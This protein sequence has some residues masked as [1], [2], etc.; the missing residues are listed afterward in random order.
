MFVATRRGAPKSF[1]EN[2]ALR[3][4]EEQR[5]AEWA[6]DQ[7]SGVRKDDHG[8]PRMD[9]LMADFQLL[10]G[11]L[12]AFGVSKYEENGWQGLNSQRMY[13]ALERHSKQWQLG[14][15]VDEDSQI[16]HMVAVAFNAMCC[17]WLAEHRPAQDDRPSKRRTDGGV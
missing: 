13:G 11:S 16:P 7:P 2:A 3:E 14:E 9:L 10:M 4:Q 12:A 8:K 5:V 1:P 17:W 15:D 6:A